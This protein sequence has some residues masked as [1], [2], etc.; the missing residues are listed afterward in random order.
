[1]TQIG[2]SKQQFKKLQ[3]YVEKDGTITPKNKI[4]VKEKIRTFS[5]DIDEVQQLLKASPIHGRKIFRDEIERHWNEL[6]RTNP[7]AWFTRRRKAEIKDKLARGE[8]PF[9]S[10]VE[11]MAINGGKAKNVGL[12]MEFLTLIFRIFSGVSF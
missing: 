12:F 5:W 11:E 6:M 2:E 9:D 4:E 10:Y 1:M 7:N 3:D 8:D